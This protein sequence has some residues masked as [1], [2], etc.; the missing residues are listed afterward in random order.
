M[1]RI[2]CEHTI[3]LCG[4]LGGRASRAVDSADPVFHAEVRDAPEVADVA[5]GERFVVTSLE[6]RPRIVDVIEI[7]PWHDLVERLWSSDFD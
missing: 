1:A 7:L 6:P 2:T 3:H 4:R 5:R